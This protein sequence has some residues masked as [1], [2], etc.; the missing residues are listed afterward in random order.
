MIMKVNFCENINFNSSVT[1][2][3]KYGIVRMNG[4][5]IPKITES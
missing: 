2:V 4:N 1:T 5:D 3:S